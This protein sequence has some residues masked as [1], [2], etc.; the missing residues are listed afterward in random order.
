MSAASGG[1]LGRLGFGAGLLLGLVAR[2]VG[3]ALGRDI[4]VDQLDHRHV[5]RVAVAH[6]GTRV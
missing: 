6:A 2:L 3:S 5:G 4:A 1:G